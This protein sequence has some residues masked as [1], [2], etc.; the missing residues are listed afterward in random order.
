MSNESGFESLEELRTMHADKLTELRDVVRRAFNEEESEKQASR[1]GGDDVEHYLNDDVQLLRF[2]TGHDADVEK[3]AKCVIETLNWRIENDVRQVEQLDM[4]EQR[5]FPFHDLVSS[6]LPA[7]LDAGR[8]RN[9]APFSIELTGQCDLVGMLQDVPIEHFMQYHIYHMAFKGTLVQELSRE[10]GRMVKLVKI[11]DLSGWSMKHVSKAAIDYLRH[12]LHTTQTAY[13]EMLH[14][15]IIIN[16]PMFFNVV[17][18][19]VAPML[20]SRTQ[21]RITVCGSNYQEALHALV[22]PAQLPEYLGGTAADPVPRIDPEAHLTEV[23]VRRG[24]SFETSVVV[25]AGDE[26]QWHFKTR[27]KDIGF[28]ARFVP[29][30]CDEVVI[31]ELSRHNSHE[32]SVRGSWTATEAGEVRL[33]FDNTYSRWTSKTLLYSLKV[34]DL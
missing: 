11:M 14:K 19:L 9:G 4:R 31:E 15:C 26:V 17:W 33:H 16:A 32:R 1:E 6:Y 29:A 27:S 34:A 5:D 21:S 18:K 28:S 12:V 22:D 25:A 8:A 24:D 10:T 13:P 2:L 7:S 20:N 30:A 23:D 3:A